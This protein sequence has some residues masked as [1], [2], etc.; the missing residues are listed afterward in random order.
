MSI[1]SGDSSRCHTFL[2]AVEY[3]TRSTWIC[4]NDVV[5]GDAERECHCVAIRIGKEVGEVVDARCAFDRYFGRCH[6]EGYRSAVNVLNVV[7][8]ECL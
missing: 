2:L 3:Y 6:F 1:G 7:A 5:F 4:L 8:Y